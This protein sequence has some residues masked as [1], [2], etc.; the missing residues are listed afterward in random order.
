MVEGPNG[1]S[2]TQLSMEAA[3]H[4]VLLELLDISGHLLFCLALGPLLILSCK[5]NQSSELV[6]LREASSESHQELPFRVL[7]SSPINLWKGELP[8]FL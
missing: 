2:R 6:T 7:I 1:S 8:A 5:K 3:T 4:L